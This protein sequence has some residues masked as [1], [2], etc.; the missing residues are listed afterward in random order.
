VR[1]W[2]ERGRREGWDLFVMYGQTEATARMAYLPPGLAC[3]RPDAVGVAVDGGSFEIEPVPG[4]PE[5]VGEVRY[6]GPNV[7]LGYAEQPEDLARG[8]DV[9]VLATGDLGRIAADGLLE[10]VGRGSRFIKPLG[11]RIDLDHGGVHR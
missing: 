7:M 6:R 2:A 8:R 4:Q 10:I 1:R 9:A 11:L 5:G 3:D